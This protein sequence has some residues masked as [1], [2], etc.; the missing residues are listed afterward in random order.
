MTAPEPTRPL[1]EAEV[2]TLAKFVD[3][4]GKL[5]DII[6]DVTKYIY[7]GYDDPIPND[8]LVAIGP[9][10]SASVRDLRR[11]RRKADAIRRLV[12]QPRPV[13]GVKIVTLAYADDEG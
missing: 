8:A 2:E 4:T 12:G 11:M 6:D 1:T 5:L 13:T 3:E 9:L 7:L 10:G